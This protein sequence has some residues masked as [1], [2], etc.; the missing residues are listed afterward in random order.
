MTRHTTAIT[1]AVTQIKATAQHPTSNTLDQPTLGEVTVWDSV[2]PEIYVDG[3][4][5]SYRPCTF[6]IPWGVEPARV[7]YA[8]IELY[9]TCDFPLGAQGQLYNIRGLLIFE[10]S[11]DPVEVFYSP[12]YPVPIPTGSGPSKVHTKG[13]MFAFAYPVFQH[14]WPF[15]CRGDFMWTIN[16][17]NWR[18]SCLPPSITF[19]AYLA[20]SNA[21]LGDDH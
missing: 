15:S 4:R 2:N 7:Y 12:E 18:K 16:V 14:P 11:V 13:F 5:G 17:T 8:P 10:G 6:N 3:K 1:W 21:V 19:L 20:I 9:G